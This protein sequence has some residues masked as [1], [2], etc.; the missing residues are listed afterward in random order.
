ML[1][2]DAADTDAAGRELAVA[3]EALYLA[4]L[5]LIPG[6][7]FVILAVLW[8]LRHRDA[9]PLARSHLRQTMAASLWAVALLIVANG[10]I[11]L[12][13]GYR[14]ASTWVVVIL[15]FTLVHSSLILCGAVGLSRA[16]AGR[17]FRFPVVG[18]REAA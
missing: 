13:G 18:P 12:L 7:G 15:Y 10:A 3:A 8:A 6:L 1:P 2:V 11:L 9:P 16:L 4:N 5:M 14:A 17:T